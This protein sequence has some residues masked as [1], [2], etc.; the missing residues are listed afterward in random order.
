MA[1]KP[2]GAV[3]RRF[4]RRFGPAA[5]P[6][7]PP[8]L[9]LAGWLALALAGL[10]GA[11]PAAACPGPAAKDDPL[12]MT[13]RRLTDPLVADVRAGG[14]VPLEL[15]DDLPGAGNV[16]FDPSVSIRYIADMRGMA[17]EFR[18]IGDCDTVILLRTPSGAWVFDDDNGPGR[19]ALIRLAAPREGRYEIRVGSRGGAAC[20][21]RLALQTF[22]APRR[23]AR[24]GGPGRL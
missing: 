22:P 10:A 16:P 17:L 13:A 14:T 9:W 15:C 4:G 23:H 24:A 5:R 8:G 11:G 6:A 2:S 19:N 21:S 20:A 3:R 7:I 18:T 12:F 1:R